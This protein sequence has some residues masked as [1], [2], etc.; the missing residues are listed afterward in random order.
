MMWPI[1]KDVTN[2]L[3]KNMW[4][5]WSKADNITNKI[6]YDQIEKISDM[7]KKKGMIK[8]EQ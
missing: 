5:T 8:S 2:D 7:M 4:G 6:D 1:L 3:I